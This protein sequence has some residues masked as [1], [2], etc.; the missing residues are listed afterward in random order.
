M[1][2]YLCTEI[3]P[4]LK[5]AKKSDYRML[6]PRTHFKNRRVISGTPVKFDKEGT[7]YFGYELN[8]PYDEKKVRGLISSIGNI[9]P[10]LLILDVDDNKTEELKL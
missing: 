2:R 9:N 7:R 6:I 8:A 3:P 1:P 5:I 4:H 10:N